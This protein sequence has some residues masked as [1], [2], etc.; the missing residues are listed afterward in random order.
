[1]IPDA[2]NSIPKLPESMPP[3][4]FATTLD[5]SGEK[6]RL[7]WGVVVPAEVIGASVGAAIAE[8]AR[9]DGAAE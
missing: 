2:A 3:I 5:R 6:G 4:A 9:P 8:F 7:D 1:M